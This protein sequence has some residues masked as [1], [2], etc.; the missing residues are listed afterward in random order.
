MYTTRFGRTIKKPEVYTPIE[1]VEDD[2]SDHEDVADS[3]VS[4][5]ISYDS[6]EEVSDTESEGS[7]KE[8]VVDEDSESEDESESDTEPVEE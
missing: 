4:S 5:T 8:F 7:L 2:F 3:D 6:E 1:E